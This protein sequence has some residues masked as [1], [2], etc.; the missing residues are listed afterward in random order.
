MDLNVGGHRIPGIAFY[1]PYNLRSY[2]PGA[3]V[4]L[5]RAFLSD[6]VIAPDLYMS[7]ISLLD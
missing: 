5:H 4:D 1:V 3:R 7:A 6:Y 2:P